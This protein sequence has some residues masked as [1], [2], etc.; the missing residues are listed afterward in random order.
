MPIGYWSLFFLA[1]S[2]KQGLFPFPSKGT[3]KLVFENHVHWRGGLY[4]FILYL[5]AVL[6]IEL[7]LHSFKE[8][9]K[10]IIKQHPWFSS[11]S[12]NYWQLLSGTIKSLVLLS[13]YVR[14]QSCFN[15]QRKPDILMIQKHRNSKGSTN[16]LLM[17]TLVHHKIFSLRIIQKLNRYIQIN[18]QSITLYVT[19][20][21]FID[22]T[23]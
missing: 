17:V 13:F 12:G 16:T 19:Y 22:N 20:G 9:I 10:Y 11:S 5:F 8:G 7:R 1:N 3:Q 21:Q 4:L 18:H 2:R 23:L 14:R 15:N 6:R